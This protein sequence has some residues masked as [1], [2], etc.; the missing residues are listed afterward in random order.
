[1]RQRAF[2]YN[3]EDLR[4]ILIPMGQNGAGTDRLHGHGYASGVS[5][6]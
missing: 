1:M 2:G 5:L 4:H 3:D 6:R